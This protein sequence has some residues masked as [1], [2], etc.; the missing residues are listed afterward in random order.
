MWLGHSLPAF[1]L[2]APVSP[3]VDR[4]SGTLSSPLPL[5]FGKPSLLLVQ[6]GSVPPENLLLR[7]PAPGLSSDT[8]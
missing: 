2:L 5:P 3:S 6:T 7:E 8:E 4:T 1:A